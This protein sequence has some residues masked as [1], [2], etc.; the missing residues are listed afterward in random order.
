MFPKQCTTL[1]CI[2]YGKWTTAAGMNG[3]S[4]TTRSV[5]GFSVWPKDTFTYGPVGLRIEPATSG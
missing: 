1:I 4:L 5:P 3:A 2:Q